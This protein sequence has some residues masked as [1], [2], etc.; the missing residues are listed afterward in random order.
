MH[1][2]PISRQDADDSFGSCRPTPQVE[3]HHR[4]KAG[5]FAPTTN[6]RLLS[7]RGWRCRF[8][9]PFDFEPHPRQPISKCAS[10]SLAD[11]VHVAAIFS[12]KQAR[13]LP[14][15][16]P[17]P[18]F[19]RASAEH[20]RHVGMMQKSN[21]SIKDPSPGPSRVQDAVMQD[22]STVCTEYIWPDNNHT[23]TDRLKDEKEIHASH[24]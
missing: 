21:Y 10:R 16:Q 20:R 8:G 24:R 7:R 9:P 12:P 18:C 2:R 13:R 6:E 14:S 19:G 5:S 11:T 3:S 23:T 15:I 17:T 4:S 22:I 1:L